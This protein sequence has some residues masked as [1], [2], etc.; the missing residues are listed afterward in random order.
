M[1]LVDVV[2]VNAVSLKRTLVNVTE[3]GPV[4]AAFAR[5]LNANN[6]VSTESNDTTR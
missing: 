5:W 6:T 1:V 4:M 3:A 2:A